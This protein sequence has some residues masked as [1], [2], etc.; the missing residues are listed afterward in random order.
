[1]HEVNRDNNNLSPMI[2]PG[3]LLNH[4]LPGSVYVGGITDGMQWE[5]VGGTLITFTVKRGLCSIH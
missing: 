5:T 4:I 3:I 1:M 2:L